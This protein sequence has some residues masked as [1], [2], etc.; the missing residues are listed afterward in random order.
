MSKQHRGRPKLFGEA[1]PVSAFMHV[2]PEHLERLDRLGIAYGVKP[3]R[4]R[5]AVIR[6]LIDRAWLELQAQS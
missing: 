2:L 6:F 1:Q 3:R 5:S 4:S